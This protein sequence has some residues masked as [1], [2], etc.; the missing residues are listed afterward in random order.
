MLHDFTGM[1]K[2]EEAMSDEHPHEEV[3]PE[4]ELSQ[5]PASTEAYSLVCNYL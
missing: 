2:Y 4:V 3:W 1:E 5:E